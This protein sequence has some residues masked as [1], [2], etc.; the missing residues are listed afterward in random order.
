MFHQNFIQYWN[1]ECVFKTVNQ[2]L[3]LQWCHSLPAVAWVSSHCQTS[4][5]PA[6]TTESLDAGRGTLSTQ[7]NNL[8]GL[9]YKLHVPASM[10]TGNQEQWSSSLSFTELLKLTFSPTI[11]VST[12]APVLNSHLWD[13]GKQAA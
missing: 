13:N 4:L 8:S 11:L 9:W 10:I 12:V 2:N 5:W 1:T 6:R 7:H 3:R